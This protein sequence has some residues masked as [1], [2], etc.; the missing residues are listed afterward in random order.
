MK[1]HKRKEFSLPVLLL[2]GAG[3]ALCTVIAISFILSIVAYMTGDPSAMI[4]A[5]SL[6]SLAL[7]GAI[8]GFVTSRVNGDGGVLVGVLSALI[9]GAIMLAIGLVCKGGLL[10]LGAVLNI[11]VFVAVS[12]FSAL[13]GKRKRRKRR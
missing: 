11:A 3:F 2:M 10:P 9:S 12:C 13:L 1:R 7:A 6:L 4:G 8:S 5:F